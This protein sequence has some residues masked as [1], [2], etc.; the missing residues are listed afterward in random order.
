MSGFTEERKELFKKLI[1]T[2]SYYNA[3]ESPQ[4]GNESNARN[5]FKNHARET[6]L[7]WL[8]DGVTVEELKTYMKTVPKLCD[9]GDFIWDSHLA[10][11]GYIEPWTDDLKRRRDEF[12]KERRDNE[13]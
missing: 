12:L 4:Y 6:L 2:M 10:I 8:E 7:T 13:L 3:A 11:R 1:G 9:F 5:H